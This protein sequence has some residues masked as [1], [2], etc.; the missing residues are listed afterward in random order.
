M[1]TNEV[2][3]EKGVL[4]SVSKEVQYALDENGRYQQVMSDGWETKDIVNGLSWEVIKE[5]AEEARER[6]EQ[7]KSSPILY[8][9]RINQMTIGLLASYMDISKL[10]VWWHLKPIGFKRLKNSRLLQYAK[11]FGITKEKLQSPDFKW[12]PPTEAGS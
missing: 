10:K 11:V 4:S 8:Y 1:K 6:I 9:M 5:Q 7:G 3:Q 12:E 2:P